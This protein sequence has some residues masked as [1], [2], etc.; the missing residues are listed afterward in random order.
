MG[1]GYL[2]VGQ[3]ITTTAGIHQNTAGILNTIK[4]SIRAD[5]TW[6]NAL[7]AASVRAVALS[8]YLHDFSTSSITLYTSIQGQ[9]ARWFWLPPN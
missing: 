6:G 5:H 4:P 7:G 2:V 9:P 3:V 1:K 8:P